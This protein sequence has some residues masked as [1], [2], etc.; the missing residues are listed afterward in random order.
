MT[1]KKSLA[2]LVLSALLLSGCS[3]INPNKE[4]KQGEFPEW[5]YSRIGQ[6]ISYILERGK[7][8]EKEYCEVNNEDLYHVHICLRYKTKEDNRI[9]PKELAPSRIIFLYHSREYMPSGDFRRNM[10]HYPNGNW[11]MLKDKAKKGIYP[12]DRGLKSVTVYFGKTKEDLTEHATDKVTVQKVGNYYFG[13]SEIF[14][15]LKE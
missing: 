13:V 3:T 8:N 4:D 1:I 2:E 7:S 14:P 12:E 11:K 9:S 15:F 5:L 10:F 6:D